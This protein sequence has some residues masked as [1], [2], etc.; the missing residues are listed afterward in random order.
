MSN[1]FFGLN[2]G[3]SSL[4]AHQTALDVTGHNLA[5]VETEGYS[6]QR[7]SLTTSLAI[8]TAQGPVGSGVNMDRIQ[9]LQL[10]YLDRQL[11]RAMT[12]HSFDATLVKGYEE[13]QTVLG[14]PSSD[15]INASLTELW[16]SWEALSVR[17]ADSSLRAQVLDRATNLALVFNQKME[18]LE[19]LEAEFETALDG[20]VGDV[21][22][23]A[24]KIASLNVSIARAE[25]GGYTANDLRDQ[26][27]LLSRRMSEKLGVELEADGS[28]L[29]I[30]L[31]G[32]GPYLVHRSEAYDLQATRNDAG[33]VTGLFAGA[34]PVSPQGGEI[35][36]LLTLR[37]DAAPALRRELSELLG[38]VT[39]RINGLH[40]AGYDRD[41]VQGL[42][43]FQWQGGVDSLSFATSSGLS[44]VEASPGLEPGTHHLAV[45][46]VTLKTSATNGLGNQPAI[47]LSVAYQD[48]ANPVFR[49]P[50]A[51][52]LD[53][54]VRVVSSNLAA[55][56]PTGLRVQLFRGDE[57]VGD[58]QAVPAGGVVAW[59]P[60]DGLVF[61]ANVDA[62][63]LLAAGSR[64]DGYS[65]VGSVSL[66]GGPA[67][68]VDLT[69]TNG[70]TFVGGIDSD[71][72]GGGS[73]TVDFTGK[74]FAGG[75]V[76]RFGQAGR[77]L[78]NPLVAADTDRIAAALP[79]ATGTAA[80][81][82]GEMARRLGALATG[83]IFEATGDTA[84]GALGRTV[85]R[86]GAA[87]R[88][89][90]VFEAASGAIEL[91]VEAQR[92]G[93]VGVNVDEEMVQMLQYQRGFEAAARFLTTVD[94]LIDTLINRVG[95]G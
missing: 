63:G 14:E 34:A 42:N 4:L 67:V 41:N 72:R 36:A 35:G 93:E 19:S 52:Q 6:R 24:E 5:N 82:N 56:D 11:G 47:G 44:S 38:T 28:D 18:G 51:I 10:G 40:H 27:E 85:Q 73:V 91:Q 64:S 74:P 92:E 75:S 69:G 77:L 84:A 57:A 89:A 12:Q 15:G 29:N 76:T 20:A 78:V 43:L 61:T 37:T 32:G 31:P 90:Q 33:E 95:A 86:L 80:T 30:R 60:I 71:F 70:F 45:S 21:N 53:Y 83:Q 54:H 68:A 8:Q 94:G 87:A 3:R 9:R 81:G 25:A 65:T 17:P 46:N 48:P 39:D 13:L 58:A 26:R 66:D 88:D 49:G 2:I 16:N 7:V 22:V 23:W 55:G 50:Q 62:S 1:I 59:A 79:S